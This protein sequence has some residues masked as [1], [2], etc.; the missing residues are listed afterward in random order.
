MI[1]L[2]NSIFASGL[3]SFAQFCGNIVPFLPVYFSFVSFTN[4]CVALLYLV[5]SFNLFLHLKSVSKLA[6]KF[7]NSLLFN[8]LK[9]FSFVCI[10]IGD[11]IYL[12][13]RLLK[14]FNFLAEN[15]L[16]SW[17]TEETERICNIAHI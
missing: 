5:L 12:D 1:C 8:G 17:E 3:L 10:K 2:I 9:L 15:F 4:G 11:R 7:L 6:F 14:T 13:R 16:H